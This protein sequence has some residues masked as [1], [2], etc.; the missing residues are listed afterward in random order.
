MKDVLPSH[1]GSVINHNG[2]I[3]GDK[4]QVLNLNRNTSNT[5][6]SNLM[7]AIDEGLIQPYR[8]YLDKF[9]HQQQIVQMRELILRII[10]ASLF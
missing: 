7:K 1:P 3:P 5:E 6:F 2:F 9:N 4:A 8:R 10:L